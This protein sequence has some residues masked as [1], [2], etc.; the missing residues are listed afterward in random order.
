[1]DIRKMSA[2]ELFSLAKQKQSDEKKWLAEEN[3]GK[4]AEIRE[5]R[6][7]IMLRQKKE[8]NEN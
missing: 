7:Q 6:R 1:M 8:I 5:E 4:I 3:K 2:D